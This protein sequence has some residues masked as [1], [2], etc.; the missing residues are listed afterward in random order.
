MLIDK[1]LLLSDGQAYTDFAV[2]DTGGTCTNAIDLGIVKDAFFN[3][4]TNAHGAEDIRLVAYAKTAIT[5]G[6]AATWLQVVV[7][8]EAADTT[9]DTPDGVNEVARGPVVLVGTSLAAG[10]KLCDIPLAIHLMKRYVTAWFMPGPTATTND[11]TAGTVD[12]YLVIGH[13]QR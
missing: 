3:A 2:A 6:N 1:N 7:L 5:S 12:C 4:L 13:T 8:S 10:S 9:P 11:L